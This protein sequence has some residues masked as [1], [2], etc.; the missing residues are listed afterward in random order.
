MTTCAWSVTRIRRSI[1]SPGDARFLTGFTAE[2]PAAAVIRLVR[3]Y[4]STPQVVALANRL[5]AE[6]PR[7]AARRAGAGPQL[8]AQ[9]PAGPQPVLTCYD[10]E[11]EAAAV[12]ARARR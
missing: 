11:A 3:D 1:P 12:A 6:L 2:F 8:V 10:E 4:R 7:R 5:V 9:R